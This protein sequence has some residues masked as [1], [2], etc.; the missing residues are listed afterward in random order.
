FAEAEYIAIELGDV[1]DVG[2]EKR[3]VAELVRNNAF[4]RKTLAREGVPL[5]YLHYGSLRILE[6]DH[7]RNRGFAVFPSLGFNAVALNLLLEVVEVVP[8]S[9]LQAE[10]RAHRLTCIGQFPGLLIELTTKIERILF[11]IRRR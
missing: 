8:R 9:S 6:P 10:Q 2:D 11:L 3:D 7:V 5:E 1:L 4:S